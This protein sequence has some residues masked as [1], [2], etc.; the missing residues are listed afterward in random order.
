MNH[1]NDILF[2]LFTR[3]DIARCG[4]DTFCVSFSDGLYIH[5]THPVIVN[6]PVL[7]NEN[8]NEKLTSGRS[9][10]MELLKEQC[11][12]VLKHK[13]EKR[14]ARLQGKRELVCL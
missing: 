5:Y 13:I 8:E 2:G 3:G 9:L 12:F 7:R 6:A 1:G 4:L 14:R 10:G 11:I